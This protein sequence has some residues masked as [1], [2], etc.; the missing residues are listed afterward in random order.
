MNPV[1]SW[2]DE[3]KRALPWRDCGDPYAIWISEVMLQQTRVA[4]ALPYWERWLL[5]FPTLESL[6]RAEEQEVLAAWQG[7]G[8]YSRARNL[9]RAAQLLSEHGWPSS[10]VEWRAVPGVGDYTS[11][12]LASL[13]LKLPEPAID[14]NV[15]RVYARYHGDGSFSLRESARAWARVLMDEKRPGD[16]NQALMELGALVCTP[17]SPQCPGCPLEQDCVARKAGTQATLPARRPKS[18]PIELTMDLA[19][20]QRCPRKGDPLVAPDST[21]LFAVTQLDHDRWWKGMW[22]WPTLS[23][24]REGELLTTF[25][26]TVTK[27]T[28]TFQAFRVAAN[29]E[30]EGLCWHTMAE[31]E[32]LPMPAPHRRIA[33][34]LR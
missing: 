1:L 33:L 18:P 32:H 28:I 11:A 17:K 29:K 27:H 22:G 34:L 24:G 14:G 20:I 7:L 4:A 30:L 12:A 19:I 3:R 9:H 26:H 21:A 6:A 13:L 8:Y 2:Y 23:E 25:K 15:E 16:S 5:R 31:L 10:L